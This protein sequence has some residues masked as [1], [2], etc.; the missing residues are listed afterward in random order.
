MPSSRLTPTTSGL[1]PEM[2]VPRAKVRIL[3]LSLCPQTL[4]FSLFPP[5]Y[6]GRGG[7]SNM[8]ICKFFF[9]FD[10]FFIDSAVIIL[11]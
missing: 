7:R 6:T 1:A 3:S 10:V 4:I 9:R 8:R 5:G 2:K 11:D